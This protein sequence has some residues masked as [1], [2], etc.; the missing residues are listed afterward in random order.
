MPHTVAPDA[1]GPPPACEHE[2]SPASAVRLFAVGHRLSLAEAESPAAFE[3]AIRATVEAD[4]APHLA[5]DR[6]NVLVFPESVAFPLVFLGPRGAAARAQDTALEAFTALVPEVVD[7]AN[8]YARFA[9]GAAGKLTLLA[10]TD[11]M[12]RA[13]DAT[14][15]G[16]ARDYGVY[17]VAGIDAGDVALTR[18]PEAVAAL[19]DPERADPRDTYWVPD[20]EV[21]NQA[22]FY[23]PTGARFAQT[24]KAYLVDLEADDLELRGGW[25][26]ALG[27]VDV[28][29][30][31]RAAPMISR[32][33]WMPDA[34]ERVA[35]RGA[36]VL[37]QLEAFVGWTV[38]PDGYPW[39]PD[40]LKRSGWAAVQRLPELRA[41]VAPMYVGNFF[42]I[43]FD[44]QSFAV[45]DGT[46]ADERRALVAQVPDVG[47]AAI[48]P[49]VEPDPGVG[50]LD[51]RRAALRAVGEALLP[52]GS[53]AGDYRAGTVWVDLDLRADDA[54]PRVDGIDVDPEPLALH[55]ARTVF[56]HGVGVK[57]S[58]AIAAGPGEQ[59]WL[60]WEDTRYCTGQILAAFSEDGG[61]TWRDPVR[62]QPWNRPQHSP[63][64]AA[65][66]DDAAL[67]VWQEV[68]GEH[69]AE[70]RAAF[71]P[72]G[73][74]T[75]SQRVRIDADAT[76]EAWVPSVAV[77]PDTGDAYVAFA[78]ARGPD[79]TW[80]VYVS[81]SPDG[82][83]TWLGAV[84]VDPR[85]RDDAARD[86]T[87]T[88]EWSP[89]IAARAGRV[90][91]AYTHRHRPDPDGQPSDDVFVA[92]SVD[93][94]ATWTAP[95]RLDDGGFPE[96]LA[97]DVAIDLGPGGEWTVVWSTVR[98]RGYD[99][100]VALA[101]SAGGPLAFAP[102]ADPPRDQWAPAIARAGDALVVAWQD[103]RNGSNDI[104]LS[105]VRDGA[106]GPAVR[107]DD[108][109]DS[110][111][112][113]WRPA[114]A[115]SAGG[116]VY[117]AWEDSRTGHAELRWARGSL[118]ASR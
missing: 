26:D 59:V 5:T 53:R 77:D 78:D 57:R 96:R 112:Q 90:V 17:V 56:P 60:A 11:G 100:D 28:G 85:D 38:A 73:G 69:R 82:G 71:S 58:A 15:S 32:D 101:T 27:P 18:D 80:R 76:V 74:R 55:G 41:A 45:V 81:R 91:V 70:I 108:G 72:D 86:R 14:F 37:L 47:W 93:G 23:D 22:V 2:P 66:H 30:L 118:P 64:I 33:A 97:M 94:G 42:D 9:T 99:A 25:P 8:Y 110:A 114:L 105:V 75:W 43:G 39:P 29:G 4:V 49:W 61:V 68:L 65:L 1:A 46:P 31:V 103:F 95:R 98:G 89:A 7:A 63:Q 109:G 117:A 35:L 84:R 113:S 92:E 16:I 13:F 52:G 3:A 104:Y 36:N 21:Y 48:A 115:A 116:V 34:L 111:A 87:L 107:V 44:G 12:W 19:A 67:A 106:F 79:P 88:A 51:D 6:P 10:V 40:N 83:R 102:D 50:S 62:I 54:L 24:H 20:G